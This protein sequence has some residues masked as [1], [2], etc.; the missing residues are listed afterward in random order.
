MIVSAENEAISCIG[1]CAFN[2]PSVSVYRN[3]PF[4]ISSIPTQND[5]AN[6]DCQTSRNIVPGLELVDSD[7][8]SRTAVLE[9]NAKPADNSES[10][11]ID[12]EPERKFLH[13]AEVALF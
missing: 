2:M 7:L 4:N 6:Q 12:S 11:S 13:P 8:D 1:P 10:C 9:D 5:V 3:N